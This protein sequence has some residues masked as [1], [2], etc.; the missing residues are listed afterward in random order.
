VCACHGY[1][2]PPGRIDVATLMQ[3]AD[4]AMFHAKARDRGNYQFFR[5]DMNR[6]AVHRP[7]V[8][9]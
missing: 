1:G 7:S 4:A 5:A 2:L 8:D 3:G 6:R 9:G